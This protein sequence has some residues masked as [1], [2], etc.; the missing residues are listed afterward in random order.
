MITLKELGVE[1]YDSIVAFDKL[2]FPTDCWKEEDWKDLLEDKMSI[3]YALLDGDQIIG[4]V[5][6]Y[7]WGTE[8]EYVKIMNLA[9]HPEYRKKGLAHQ[10]LNHVTDEM[11]V[12]EMK[13]F[14]GETR[15]SNQSMQTVFKDCGYELNKIEENYFESPNES[16][17]KFA[18]QL[19]G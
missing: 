14:C 10:L 7:N 16:A 3:Y 9:I 1:Q 2:C 4:D 5:F 15:S 13:R 11:K 17:Y 8:K 12:L 19:L 6:I 18:L